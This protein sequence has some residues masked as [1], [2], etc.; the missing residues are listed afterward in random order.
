MT[1]IFQ[2]HQKLTRK[3][4]KDYEEFYTKK[5]GWNADDVIMTLSSVNH[6]DNLQIIGLLENILDELR[7]KNDG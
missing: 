2:K 4:M 1:N 7:K 6:V 5:G 3:L